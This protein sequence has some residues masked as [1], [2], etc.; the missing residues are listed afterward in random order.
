MKTDRQVGAEYTSREDGWLYWVNQERRI[1]R[2]V[3]GCE[4]PTIDSLPAWLPA[5]AHVL[6]G[7]GWGFRM[8]ISTFYQ[9]VIAR[10]GINGRK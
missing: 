3:D 10:S 8:H 6:T 9:Q 7:A 1:C 5:G 2:V 4:L